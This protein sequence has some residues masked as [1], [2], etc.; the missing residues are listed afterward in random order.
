MECMSYS[1]YTESP[2]TSFFPFNTSPVL[3]DQQATLS[4]TIPR[5]G[6]PR[7]QGK[8]SEKVLTL[9]GPAPAPAQP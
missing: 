9:R 5:E 6:A 7:P 2:R 1:G 3:L 4:Q 8:A